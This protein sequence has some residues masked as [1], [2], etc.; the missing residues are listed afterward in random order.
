MVAFLPS[1]EKVMEK[2]NKINMN[3]AKALHVDAK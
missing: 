1:K 2:G 3:P